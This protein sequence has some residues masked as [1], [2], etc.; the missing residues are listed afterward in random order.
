MT[1]KNLKTNKMDIVVSAT[2]ATLG[3]IPYVGGF[4]SEIIQNV[5][6]N[7]RQDRIVKFITSL[8]EELEQMK[9]SQEEL[10]EKYL[11]LRYCNFTYS[12]FRYVCN[13]VYDEKINYY[14]HL[15]L[16]AISKDESNLIHLERILN[17]LSKLDY[18][19][20]QY[21]RFYS[22][23]NLGG[24]EIMNDVVNKIGFN[25]LQPSYYMGMQQ[26]KM[27]EETYKQITLNNLC[28]EGLLA[29]EIKIS[30]RTERYSYKITTLGRLILRKIGAENNE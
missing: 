12:C 16:D 28:N 2:S 24:T 22:D 7:Q 1:E 6:P 27:D 11:N 19:E 10:K 18:Y 5:I 14:K 29:R 8:N 9:I 26:D 15:L 30:G 20:I 25:I 3:L 21:L 17:I 13:E 4:L 23:C